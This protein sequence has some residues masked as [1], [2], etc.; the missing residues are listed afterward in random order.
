[1]QDVAP[2]ADAGTALHEHLRTILTRPTFT[3]LIDANIVLTSRC[4]MPKEAGT[5]ERLFEAVLALLCVLF[6]L[7][8]HTSHKTL[9]LRGNVDCLSS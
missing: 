7:Q 2:G 3:H 4:K 1:M 9:R 8:G 6:A 5:A